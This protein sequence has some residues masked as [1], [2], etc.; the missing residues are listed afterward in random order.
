MHKMHCTR[1]DI[2]FTMD[3]LSRYTSC[4]SSEHW[5]AISNVLGYLKATKSY[6]LFYGGSPSV[7]EGY[8][9]ANWNCVDDGS[10]STSGWIFTLGGAAIT[11]ASKKQTCITHST[12]ESEL[13]ALGAA[14][15]EAEW[16]KNFLV[17]LPMWQS[18]M[19]PISIHCDSQATLLRV[20][21]KSYNGKSRHISLRHNTVRQLLEEDTITVAYI[22]SCSNLADPLIKGLNKD[23]V[24]KT[25]VE[26]G[27]KLL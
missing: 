1:P 6:A 13:V 27:L 2:A 16:L 12:M 15:K 9:D 4:P 8:S 20:Y 5:K 22:K 18:P 19:P 3:K 23:L 21:S 11:W 10:K 14:G 7:V 25:S 17:E 24:H 26:M